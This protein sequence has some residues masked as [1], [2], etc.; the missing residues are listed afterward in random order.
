MFC[1]CFG[2]EESTKKKP[3]RTEAGKIPKGR[4]KLQ[5]KHCF[6]KSFN[7]GNITKHMTRE[8]PTKW[9]SYQAV[10]ANRRSDPLSLKKF[11]V[12]PQITAFYM[13]ES[14][15]D[16]TVTRFV[17]KEIVE[18]IVKDILM[19]QQDNASEDSSGLPAN[20]R[21]MKIFQQVLNEDGDVEGYSFKIKNRKQFN[22]VISLAGKGFSFCQIEFAV[23]TIKDSY[24]I[25]GTMGCVSEGDASSMVR[26]ACAQGLQLLAVAMRNS[27]AFSIG[28][29]ESNN[30]GADSHLDVRVQFPAIDNVQQNDFHLMA[31]PMRDRSHTGEQYASAV[32]RVLNILCP[33]WRKKLIGTSSDGAGNMAGHVPCWWVFY[34]PNGRIRI[35][36]CFLSHLVFGSPA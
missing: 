15:R 6:T 27:W 21:A 14:E 24:N 36:R 9:K 35:S 2:R 34:S 18:V 28:A 25:A 7:P 12:Q 30:G 10:L 16:G 1:L 33:D 8:H 20:D 32:K 17:E 31:I 29:D 26:M 19:D 3:I 5:K 23:A 11:F 22:F 4:G 13:K